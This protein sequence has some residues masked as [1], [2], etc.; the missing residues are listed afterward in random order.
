MKM[1]RSE[2]GFSFNWAPIQS[3]L[4]WFFAFVLDKTI[5]RRIPNY[6]L[7]TWNINVSCSP[8]LKQNNNLPTSYNYF[9][10]F[11]RFHRTT[12]VNRVTFNSSILLCSWAL[13]WGWGAQ[14]PGSHISSRV[15]RRAAISRRRRLAPP[16]RVAATRRADHLA[17]TAVD[18]DK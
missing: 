10:C 5:I 16:R 14:S 18:K 8:N 12:Q 9:L 7:R 13:V 6:L 3:S 1:S 2:C 15:S 17:D 11:F 4:C